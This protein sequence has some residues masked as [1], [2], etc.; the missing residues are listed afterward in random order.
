MGAA[1]DLNHAL[2]DLIA[3]WAGL[4]PD[5]PLELP[6]SLASIDKS[7]DWARVT[8]DSDDAPVHVSAGP[9]SAER[10][11]ESIQAEFF[12]L[13]A[14]GRYRGVELADSWADLWRHDATSGAP[15]I[16]GVTFQPTRVLWIRGAEAEGG[17]LKTDCLTQFERDFQP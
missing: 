15:P 10:F 6:G 5:C 1:A 16:P 7:G 17:R 3:T 12:T 8:W 11:F 2:S 9:G 14:K 4:H 13:P